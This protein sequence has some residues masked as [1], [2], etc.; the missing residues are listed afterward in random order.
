[1]VALEINAVAHVEIQITARTEHC[2]LRPLYCCDR[3]GHATPSPFNDDRRLLPAHA[4]SAT[5]AVGQSANI[6][7]LLS[8]FVGE[9]S[10]ESGQ[11]SPSA[12]LQWASDPFSPRE[13]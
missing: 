8:W 7:K 2:R 10:G 5:P 3:V 12:S 1:M 9:E 4:L 13:T 6:G 11:P